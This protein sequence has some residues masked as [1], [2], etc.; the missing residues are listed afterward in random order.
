MVPKPKDPLA[1]VKMASAN[2]RPHL[3]LETPDTTEESS[4]SDEEPS[5]DE[6]EE[7][8][9]HE[10]GEEPEENNKEIQV[11]FEARVPHAR[12]FHGIVRLL[13]GMFKQPHSVNVTELTEYII[14]QRNVG[15]VITQSM[16][17]FDEDGDD[18]DEDEFDG[19]ILNEVFG[20]NTVVHLNK[21]NN[22]TKP[23]I[24][25]LVNSVTKAQPD[26]LLKLSAL[27]ND[28]ANKIGLI[29]SERIMN[30]PPQISVPLYE[31]LF[32]EIRK[33]RAK[34]FPF[35]FNYLFLIAKQLHDTDGAADVVYTNAEEEVIKERSNHVLEVVL[36]NEE[37]APKKMDWSD[38]Q[39]DEKYKILVF[40]WDKC[41]EILSSIKNSFP[42]HS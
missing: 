12:D 41:E 29:I 26:N 34:K 36:P 6:E 13:S 38:T 42:M 15:S 30:I 1:I 20:V 23:L 24:E 4:S 33:A 27:L 3:A 7:E 25:Y 19:E 5:G 37:A 35:D 9:D 8:E 16:N 17:P 2:K 28:E 31:T 11:E 39:Y 10:V 21:D 18:S 14:N 40:A 22:V 32:N